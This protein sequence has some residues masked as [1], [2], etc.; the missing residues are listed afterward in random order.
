MGGRGL[1]RLEAA[2]GE[3]LWQGVEKLPGEWLVGLMLLAQWRFEKPAQHLDSK[4]HGLEAHNSCNV[5]SVPRC[6]EIGQP[7]L[8]G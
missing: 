8:N 5:Q 7:C 3:P 6:F 4:L 2:A 1:A